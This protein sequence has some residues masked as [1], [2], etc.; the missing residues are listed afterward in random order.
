MINYLVV[1]NA[2]LSKYVDD[3]TISERVAKVELSNGQRTVYR[4]AQWSLENRVQLK[5]EK[6]KEMRISFTK[7]QQEFE[8][9]LI[10]GDSL[11]VID[12]V[13]LLGLNISGDLTW[14][15]HINEIVK[16]AS[17]RLYFLV[18]LKRAKVTRTDVGLF[19]SSCIRSIMDYAVQA[20]H[21]SLPKYLRQELERVQKRA[22]SRF[23]TV[24]KVAL[25]SFHVLKHLTYR[26]EF[27]NFAA[28]ISITF[29][30]ISSLVSFFIPFN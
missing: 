13:K 30:S 25:S 17:K 12:S 21:F 26:L 11:E 28:C 19:Y 27:S 22:M 9:I 1:Q 3:T 16:K 7:S 29:F 6:C 4:V 20:F 15:I 2:R 24:L 8:P 23:K 14:N 10:N 18:Q 5:T